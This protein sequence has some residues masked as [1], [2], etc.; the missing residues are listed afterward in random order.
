[1]HLTDGPHARYLKVK[2]RESQSMP[3]DKRKEI[4]QVLPD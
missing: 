3:L 1:V 4:V 2:C